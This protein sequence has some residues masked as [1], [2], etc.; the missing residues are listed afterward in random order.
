MEFEFT[1]RAQPST[2]TI[3]PWGAAHSPFGRYM[4]SIGRMCFKF[5][6]TFFS[7]NIF[8]SGAYVP[9]QIWPSYFKVL[10]WEWVYVYFWWTLPLISTYKAQLF[11]LGCELL[12]NLTGDMF[13][14]VKSCVESTTQIAII[15]TV[16]NTSGR[17][18]NRSAAV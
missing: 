18:V 4:L 17:L 16:N 14:K 3:I 8:Y 5:A 10:F 12:D 11:S 9:T 6:M 13:I 7:L 2:L 15:Q 1:S